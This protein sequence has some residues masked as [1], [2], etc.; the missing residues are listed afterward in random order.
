MLSLVALMGAA[1]AHAT[2]SSAAVWAAETAY[3][4]DPAGT[5]KVKVL[6]E[7]EKYI[8]GVGKHNVEDGLH[9]YLVQFKDGVCNPKTAEVTEINN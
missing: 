6:V 8:V 7:G 5:S 9:S 2:C 3:G 1:S 4:N